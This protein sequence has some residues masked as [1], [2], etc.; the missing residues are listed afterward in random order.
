MEAGLGIEAEEPAAPA[1][2]EPAPVPDG[3]PE[4]AAEESA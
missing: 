1:E 2:G 4:A 3:A